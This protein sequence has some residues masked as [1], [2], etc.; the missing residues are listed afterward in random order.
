MHSGAVGDTR[1]R[2]NEGET[3][4]PSSQ[5]ADGSWRKPRKVKSGYIPQEEQP[6]YE[7]K[8][9]QM[10][11]EQPTYPVGLSPE[12]LLAHRLAV[13]K[14]TGVGASKPVKPIASIDRPNAPITAEQQIAKKIRNLEKKL[15]D[16]DQLKRRIDD[17]ELKQPEKTQLDKIE[18]RPEVQSEID[19]LMQQ[20][21]NL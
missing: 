18:R 6:K 19:I 14:S 12:Q 9:R 8:G 13:E 2:T 1:V 7:S 5:R 16:I 17:G 11:R 4:I 3:Y 21:S 15:N 10:A 20:L